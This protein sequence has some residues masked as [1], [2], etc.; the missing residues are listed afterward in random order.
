M[1]LKHVF[2][3]ALQKHR[4]IPT[5]KKKNRKN[6]CSDFDL[7]LDDAICFGLIKKN[8]LKIVRW[9]HYSHHKTW[10]KHEIQRNWLKSSKCVNDKKH[11]LNWIESLN[12]RRKHF[13]RNES[14][15]NWKALVRIHVKCFQHSMASKNALIKGV[16]FSSNFSSSFS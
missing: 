1:R 2:F 13:D 6:R 10:M 3:F 5:S 11:K 12:L 9:S 15:L 7:F 16:H 14:R 4:T 8:L